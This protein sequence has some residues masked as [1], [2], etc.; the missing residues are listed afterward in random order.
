[1]EFKQKIEPYIP[2]VYKYLDKKFADMFFPTNDAENGTLRLS[3]LEYYAEFDD[4]QRGD[5]LEC[6]APLEINSESG[7]ELGLYANNVKAIRDKIYVLCLSTA[8]SRES[9]EMFRTDYCIELRNLQLLMNEIAS[10]IKGCNRVNYGPV[11]YGVTPKANVT[12][13]ETVNLNWSMP[14]ATDKIIPEKI[15]LEKWVVDKQTSI[16]F[17][18][19]DIYWNQHEYRIAFYVE[20]AQGSHINVAITSTLAKGCSI[21]PLS[22]LD[23]IE[24]QEI[25]YYADSCNNCGNKGDM[26]DSYGQLYGNTTYCKKNTPNEPPLYIGREKKS[27]YE[28]E[29]WMP[30][31]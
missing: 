29:A 28:C 22:D 2:K 26:L 30:I 24:E 16:P 8:H 27:K 17:Q 23:I 7:E 19:E 4:M 18:K 6:C 5:F 15:P 14:G 31:K 9:Y 25:E 21:I 10:Q 13:D 11:V 1:M 20:Y 12:V 3:S